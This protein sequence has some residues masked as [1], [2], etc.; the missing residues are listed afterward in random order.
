MHREESTRELYSLKYGERV[1][2]R[3]K[4]TN[5]WLTRFGHDEYK[6]KAVRGVTVMV[7]DAHGKEIT[8]DRTWFKRKRKFED[9][10]GGSRV[11]AKE[12]GGERQRRETS[13]LK[14]MNAF[15]CNAIDFIF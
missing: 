14:E 12:P 4:R 7:T 3:Q 15:R 8:R 13:R 5:K 10:N 11:K 2:A 9:P 6:V 1:H